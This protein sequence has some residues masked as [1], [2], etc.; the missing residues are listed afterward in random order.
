MYFLQPN[1]PT[2]PPPKDAPLLEGKK[3]VVLTHAVSGVGMEFQS[4]DRDITK[5]VVAILKEKVKKIDVVEP[6]KIFSWVDDH[7]QWTSSEEI[8]KARTEADVVI[9]LEIETFQIQNAGDIGVFEGTAKT[10]IMV[11]EM[12]HPKNESAAQAGQ[13]SSPREAKEGYDA[14]Y[15][16]TVFPDPAVPSPSIRA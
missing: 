13:R 16:D 2:I 6:D 10:H 14:A 8:A 7:P 1:E 4:L 9:F 15:Q 3:V 5:K 12:V 11:T